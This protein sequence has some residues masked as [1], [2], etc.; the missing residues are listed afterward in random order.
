MPNKIQKIQVNFP[1]PVELPPGFEHT[2]V[3]L[4]DMVCGAYEV[5]NPG[6]TMWPITVG[7]DV[8][9]DC[10]DESKIGNAVFQIGVAERKAHNGT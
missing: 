2:L 4:I 8:T 10:P 1:V 7:T 3:C 9:V 6:R 5:A